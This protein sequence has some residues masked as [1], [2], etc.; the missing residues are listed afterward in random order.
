MAEQVLATDALIREDVGLGGA[1][2]DYTVQEAPECVGNQGGV[3]DVAPNRTI[4]H[5]VLDGLSGDG[6]YLRCR[7]QARAFI[8][9][10]RRQ[11]SRVRLEVRAGVEAPRS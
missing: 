1:Y 10:K 2:L 11:L 8:G 3:A 4:L 9:A 5:T 6:V 7:F